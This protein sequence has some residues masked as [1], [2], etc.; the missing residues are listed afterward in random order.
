[1]EIQRGVCDIVGRPA[2]MVDHGDFVAAHEQIFRFHLV[3]P[4]GI[5]HD[6]ERP[7][8][9]HDDALLDADKGLRVFRQ[10][11]Q[12]VDHLL[13][14]VGVR[15]DDDVRRLPHL[16]CDAA[17]AGGSAHAV[18]IGESVPHDEERGCIPDQLAQGGGHTSTTRIST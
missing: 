13:G 14:H 2:V 12:P 15:I 11:F 8:V 4:V 1:M 6:E 7:A 16:P 3:R 10:L 17:D 5:H 18:Q 9:G